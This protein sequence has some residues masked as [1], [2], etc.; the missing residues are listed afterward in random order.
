MAR[1]EAAKIRLREVKT[2]ENVVWALAVVVIGGGILDWNF[3]SAST[4]TVFV[5]IGVV[6]VVVAGA[7]TLRHS[8][9]VSALARGEI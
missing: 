8:R 9:M 1:L 5:V 2:M 3:G 4:G 6:L 7:L